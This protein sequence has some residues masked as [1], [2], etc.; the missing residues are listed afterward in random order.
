M[1]PNAE[2]EQRKRDLTA[3]GF[4]LLIH[5]LVAAAFLLSHLIFFNDMDEYRGPVLVKLGRADAPDEKTDQQPSLPVH[6]EEQQVSSEDTEQQSPEEIKTGDPVET[7]KIDEPEV[8]DAVERTVSDTE[9][10]DRGNSQESS[11]QTSETSSTATDE[12]SMV[13]AEETVSVTKGSEEGN[14][15]ETT[16]EASP[17]LVGRNWWIPIYMYMPLPQFVGT[18]IFDSIAGDEELENRPGKRD[19]DSKKSFLL[20]YYDFTGDE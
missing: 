2:K 13:E 18:P 7:A 4:A 11:E 16:Y 19:A 17:G 3:I 12:N 15:Y 5:I 6:Q 10:G 20:K 8:V 9:S 14:A 1:S